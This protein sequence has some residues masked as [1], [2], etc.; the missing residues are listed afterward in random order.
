MF[1]TEILL[2]LNE[3]WGRSA[4][5]EEFY[6]PIHYLPHREVMVTQDNSTQAFSTELLNYIIAFATQ[7][8]SGHYKI[9]GGWPRGFLFA[10]LIKICF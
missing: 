4:F 10:T 9:F 3:V 2:F 6:L 8:K 7:G 1:E 5:D